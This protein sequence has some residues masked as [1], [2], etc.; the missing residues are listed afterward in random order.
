VESS[1]GIIKPIAMTRDEL[2]KV[3]PEFGKE[4]DMK[5]LPCSMID[6]NELERHPEMPFIVNL[7]SHLTLK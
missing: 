3:V 4:Y 1:N 5:K 6:C 7:K 2:M